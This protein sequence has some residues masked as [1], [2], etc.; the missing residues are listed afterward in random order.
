ME[1][2]H[3]AKLMVVLLVLHAIQG[4]IIQQPEDQIF[5]LVYRAIQEHLIQILEVRH[6]KPVVQVHL[7]QIVEA[8]IARIANY[9]IQELTTLIKEAQSVKHVDLVLIIPKVGV[10]QFLIVNFVV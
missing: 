7:T 10:L 6:V 1:S 4:H 8:Q 9:A 3:I 2:G 5:W